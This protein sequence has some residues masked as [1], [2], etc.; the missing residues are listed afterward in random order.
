MKL[1][2]LLGLSLVATGGLLT[3]GCSGSGSYVGYSVYSGYNYPYYGYGYGYRD[4][5]HD[6]DFDR[7][8]LRNR[9]RQGGSIGRPVTRPSGGLHGGGGMS[10]GGMSRGGGRR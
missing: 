10:R 4:Y 7:D 1:Y 2:K 3:M 9:D 6:H 8:R 5:D